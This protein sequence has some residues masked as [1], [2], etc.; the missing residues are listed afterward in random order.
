LDNF[1]RVNAPTLGSNWSIGPG[2]YAIQIIND[3]IESA[4]QGQAPGQ[5]HGKEY[6]TGVAFPGDQW[7]QAQVVSTTNDVNGAIVRYQGTVDTHY[8][9]FVS[10]FG[11]PGTCSVAIDRDISGAPVVLAT[12]STYCTVSS[13]DFVRLQVQGSLLSYIDV[14][15]GSLLLTAMDSQIT[16]GFPG[17]SLN[18][19]GGTPVAANWSGGQVGP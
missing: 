11:G 12:D 10:H 2:Y 18:P 9:G 6:Y 8:V 4:G 1:N 5:G 19:N 3:Q 16:G 17:W 14:T 7:S 15:T 13:G